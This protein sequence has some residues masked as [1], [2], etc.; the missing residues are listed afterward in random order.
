MNECSLLPRCIGFLRYTRK[1]YSILRPQEKYG[2]SCA[3]FN[4]THKHC[5]DTTYRNP[6][7]S[8]NTCGKWGVK[9]P[10]ALK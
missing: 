9:F 4:E 1:F 7:K 10:I 5:A 3:G 6:E 2:P 8:K